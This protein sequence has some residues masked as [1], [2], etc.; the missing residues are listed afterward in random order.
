MAKDEKEKEQVTIYDFV[1]P[2]KITAFLEAYSPASEQTMA[3]EI[4]DD[5]RLRTF[6]RAY[7]IAKVGDP[8]SAYVSSL[9]DAGFK[10]QVSLQGEPAIFANVRV[11]IN[12]KKLSEGYF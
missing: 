10:M 5:A 12:E 8:L 7:P 9:E 2:Q 4:F 3:T 11:H 6:F 1:V